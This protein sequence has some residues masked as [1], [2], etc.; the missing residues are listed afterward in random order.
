[1]KGTAL[2]VKSLL[3]LCV[4]DDLSM[5]EFYGSLLGREGY[6]VVSANSG[7]QALDLVQSM[8]NVVDA[9]ILDYELP[10]MNG[11]E[12]AVQ[13]KQHDPGLPILMI[14]GSHPELEKMAPFVDAAL[15]KGVPV[16]H[17]VEGIGVLVSSRRERRSMS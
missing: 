8:N 16:Q 13:L 12:L 2:L 17:I 3:V 11:F 15:N 5:R 1:L 14:S 7:L 9:E 10:G 6:E 4:D